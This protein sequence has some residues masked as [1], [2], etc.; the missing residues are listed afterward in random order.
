MAVVISDISCA[1]NYQKVA[2][3]GA[4]YGDPI[5]P[6]LGGCL[7]EL[8][9]NTID[10]ASV[11]IF[12]EAPLAATTPASA[13]AVYGESNTSQAVNTLK[14]VPMNNFFDKMT[15]MFGAQLSSLPYDKGAVE[16]SKLANKSAKQNANVEIACL[17]TEG[18]TSKYTLA[19]TETDEEKL[20]LQ[21]KAVLTAI[22]TM[23]GYGCFPKVAIV[24]PTLYGYVVRIAGA[25]LKSDEANKRL[26]GYDIGFYNG[27]YWVMT[28]AI[29][30]LAPAAISY[31]DYAGIPH[32][33]TKAV[34]NTVDA[35]VIDGEFFCS[36]E[37]I[38]GFG[39]KDGG[40]NF[41][42]VGAT[43]NSQLG[44]RLLD[45]HAAYAVLPNS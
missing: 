14:T 15:T 26:I 18:S 25:A 21:Y 10:A 33:V 40:T 20:A 45:A 8:D 23:R 24:S 27:I 44:V 1:E 5:V 7:T 43:M 41:N 22:D 6:E 31:Y 16:L 2:K 19:G 13:P 17:L 12:Y 42:G 28:P 34:L 29:G 9:F 36:I 30:A 4:T 38:N 32:S 37:R 3:F 11:S 39:L 35:I